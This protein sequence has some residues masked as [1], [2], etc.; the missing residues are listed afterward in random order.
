VSGSEIST[1][2]SVGV[3]VGVVADVAIAFD[4]TLL[5]LHGSFEE[6]VDVGG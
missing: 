2:L 3:C 4:G 6:D 1:L 5:S